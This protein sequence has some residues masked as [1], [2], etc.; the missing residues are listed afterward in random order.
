[1]TFQCCFNRH[2]CPKKDGGHP[3]GTPHPDHRPTETHP[4]DIPHPEPLPTDDPIDGEFGSCL[5]YEDNEVV[6]SKKTLAVAAISSFLILI[7]AIMSSVYCALICATKKKSPPK[8][9]GMKV[10]TIQ[11]NDANT[12]K[13][14]LIAWE[15]P[16]IFQRTYYNTTIFVVLFN[17]NTHKTQI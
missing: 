7:L 3:T 14:D 5:C 4:T 6:I 2:A 13:K 15:K 12:E 10:Y 8:P 16:W 1:M 17:V 9:K 11:T